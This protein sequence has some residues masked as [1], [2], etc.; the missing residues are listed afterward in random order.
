[1]INSYSQLLLLLGQLMVIY[2]ISRLAINEIF[3]VLRIFIKN[4]RLVFALVSIIFLPGTIIH[5]LAHFFMATILFMRVHSLA[6]FPRMEHHYIKLGSVVYEKKD[7]FRGILVGIAPILVGLLVFYLVDFSKLFPNS[8]LYIN[9]VITYLIFTISSTMFSSKQ[10]LVDLIFI[11]PLGIIVVGLIY[12]FNIRLDLIFKNQYLISGFEGFAKKT[13]SF[14]LISL[15]IN[16]FL[17]ILFKGFRFLL[18]R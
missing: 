10:D 16:I 11:I 9:I 15:T 5:E 7:V 13:N 4:D 8:N 3:H 18:K 14:L 17:I 1:M 6:I 12:I 2:F